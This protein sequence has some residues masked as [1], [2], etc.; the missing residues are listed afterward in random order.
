MYLFQILLD[1]LYYAVILMNNQSAHLK[2]KL[3]Q[4][5]QDKRYNETK[6]W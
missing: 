6:I 1:N 5:D 3:L 4:P 2:S